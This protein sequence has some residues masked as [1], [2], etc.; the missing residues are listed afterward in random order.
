MGRDLLIFLVT[1]AILLYKLIPTHPM[2]VPGSLCIAYSRK[3]GETHE[4]REASKCHMS[5]KAGSK[6]FRRSP[7][8]DLEAVNT[9]KR[10]RLWPAELP[11]G[12]SQNYPAGCKSCRELQ[13]CNFLQLSPDFFS[14]TWLI[15]NYSCSDK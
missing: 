8:Q 1:R 2:A 12:D 13:G 11:G 9:R 4:T 10:N 7:P 5:G 15:L 3:V 6:R 14:V